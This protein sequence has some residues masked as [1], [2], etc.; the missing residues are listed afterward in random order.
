MPAEIDIA[1][2]STFLQKCAGFDPYFI[3]KNVEIGLLDVLPDKLKKLL[4]EVEGN[5]DGVLHYS[6]MSVVYNTKRRVP[7]FAAYNIDGNDQPTSIRRPPF[8]RDPRIPASVQLGNDFYDLR[9]DITEFE[10]GHM[11]SND[12]MGRGKDGKLKAYQ[13]FFFTNSVPQAERLNSG[14][15]RSL[16]SYIIH[17]ASTVSGN[18]R[19]SVFT[20]PVLTTK[21][22]K[23]VKDPSFRIPLLFFK[24]IV[25]PSNNKVYATAFIM[26]HEKRLREHKMFSPEREGMRELKPPPLFDDYPY[27]KV[28]QVNIPMLEELSG[29][30]FQW[31]GVEHLTVPENRKLVQ[32]IKGVSSAAEAKDAIRTRSLKPGMRLVEATEADLDKPGFV[33]NIILP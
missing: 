20:G 24:V 1:F 13:T 12:E 17:E 22:P 33:L 8:V 25:F 4:P 26:S 19:I 3:D 9:T 31:N 23:Y 5:E 2:S 32:L 10:I 16:E 14:L 21:D 29:L 28:F 27:R 11:A 6:G 18:G 7:F 30:R 15:W